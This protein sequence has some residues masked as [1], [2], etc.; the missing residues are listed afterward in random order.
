MYVVSYFANYQQE[1]HYL[2]G[3]K[4]TEDPKGEFIGKY[5]T[6]AGLTVRILRLLWKA[7]NLLNMLHV[8]VTSGEGFWLT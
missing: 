7:L 6:P 4:S 8:K 1:I 3:V 2:L 5:T